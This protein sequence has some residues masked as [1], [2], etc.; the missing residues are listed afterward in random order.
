MSLHVVRLVD[1][2]P[3]PWRNGGGVTRELL[4]WPGPDDWLLRLS[5]ADIEQDGPFSMFTGIDR[6]FAVLTGNGVRLGT[7]GR[8]VVTG[9]APLLFDG[10]T[11][12]AC[13]LINGPTRDLNLMVRRG[14]AEAW[15]RHVDGSFIWPSSIPAGDAPNVPS[16]LRGVFTA[17]GCVLQCYADHKIGLPAMSLAWSAQTNRHDRWLVTNAEGDHATFAFECTCIGNREK[18]DV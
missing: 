17:G 5:V 2:E 3:Q 6:W 14:P 1:I 12:P 8:T 9:E 16:R 18:R 11:A 10:A 15:M 4:T 13:E 7:P